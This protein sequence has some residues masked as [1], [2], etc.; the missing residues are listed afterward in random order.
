[1]DVLEPS[2]VEFREK[3]RSSSGWAVDNSFRRSASITFN[4]GNYAV[5]LQSTVCNLGVHLDGQW[6]F[7]CS[8]SAGHHSTSSASS[9][10]C[11][12]RSPLMHVQPLYMHSLPTGLTTVTACW[13]ESEMLQSINCR[14]C[15]E[16]RPAWAWSSVSASS[17]QFRLT[18]VTVSIGF[19]SV[20]E[21]TSS[22]VFSFTS[23]SMASLL[24]TSRRC[25]YRNQLF[26][27]SPVFARRREVIFLC[28]EQKRKQ[29][30]L[31]ASPLLGPPS[32]TIYLAIWG[33]LP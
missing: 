26:Q 32:G 29:L 25:L 33:T 16:W 27:P 7:T 15:C 21:S 30:G 22:W 13:L 19:P 5:T 24:H 11:V 23:V 18:F 1:M 8:V 4:S 9:G 28:R 2:E 20:Q 10:P 3:K 12:A 17:I 14:L 6:R 31:E